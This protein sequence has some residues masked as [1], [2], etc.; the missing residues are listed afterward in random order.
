M[1]VHDSF[2]AKY[3]DLFDA[4]P[5]I[6]Q[7]YNLNGGVKRLNGTDD[8]DQLIVN[9]A[10]RFFVSRFRSVAFQPNG[11]LGRLV[12]SRHKL[13]AKEICEAES[14]SKTF[15]KSDKLITRSM[16]GAKTENLTI[17]TSELFGAGEVTTKYI[18]LKIETTNVESKDL[19]LYFSRPLD[20]QNGTKF[21][22]PRSLL[23]IDNVGPPASYFLLDDGL[24]H[25]E[26][27]LKLSALKI[28]SRSE[29]LV[30]VSIWPSTTLH[31]GMDQ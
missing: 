3:P 28:E 27:L 17:K 14:L 15:F 12:L 16:G 6:D 5:G 22:G 1:L 13:Q 2:I 7:M 11:D 25:E 29:R 10:E 18:C 31:T 9:S 26:I 24:A 20:Y 21:W 23:P 30:E 4:I 8:F 19:R